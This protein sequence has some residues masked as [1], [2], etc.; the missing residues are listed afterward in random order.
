MEI[1]K[2]IQQVL[3]DSFSTLQFEPKTHT[4]TE[5]G[6]ILPSVS[7]KVN[8]H[9]PKFDAEAILPLSAKKEKVTVDELR[10]RWQTTNKSACDLGTDTHDFLEN[11]TG[12]ETPDT[13]QKKAGIA[14]L[15]DY[16]KDY[17]IVAKEIRMFSPRYRFAGTADLLLYNKVTDELVIGDYKTNADL[18]KAYDFLYA[19]F[20]TME[21]SP[22]NKYQLQLSYYQIMLDEALT[23]IGIRVSGRKLISLKVDASY[24]VFETIDF[25][26][27][28][29]SILNANRRVNTKGSILVL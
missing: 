18:F 11:F 16:S 20:E 26:T 2:K 21:S 13:P 1:I 8:N 6:E 23:K 9:A 24:R 10:R 25:T 12:L 5:S 4:Y 19:P 7:G 27:E 22:F 15:S 17:E 3:T 29:I 14:F 28:L